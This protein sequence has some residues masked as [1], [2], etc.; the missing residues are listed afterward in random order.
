M[1]KL[2]LYAKIHFLPFL[3]RFHFC[4][5][6]FLIFQALGVLK[7]KAV[8]FHGYAEDSQREGEEL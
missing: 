4:S 3:I 2:S 7:E 5:I 1:S 6:T 8:M